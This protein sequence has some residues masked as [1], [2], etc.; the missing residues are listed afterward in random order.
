ML[1]DINLL[2]RK[3][4]KS[5]LSPILFICLSLL[6]L[7]TAY[8]IGMDYYE[9]SVQLDQKEKA[10]EQEKK[11]VQVQQQQLQKQSEPKISSGPLLE[12]VEYVRSKE[13]EAVG[14]LQQLVAL[15]PERGYFMKY[16][17]KDRSTITIDTQF[18]TL[19]DTSHYLHELTNTRYLTE[20]KIVKMETTNFEEVADGED[21]TEF[22]G[23]LPRYHA[24]YE[25]QFKKENLHELSGEE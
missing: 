22:E 17:Y 12:K 10:L 15:L 16:E 8:W 3:E 18:D 5:F 2:P 24:Q 21:T 13:I 1:V 14:L 20:A 23:Y 7:G 19:A 4:K 11:L 25:I 9:T 6:F